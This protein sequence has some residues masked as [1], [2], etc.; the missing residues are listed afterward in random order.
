MIDVA[1]PP[2]PVRA[3]IQLGG[4]KSISNR[5]LII[6]QVLEAGLTF[7]NLSEGDDTTLLKNALARVNNPGD[8][9]INVN[10]AGTDMRFLTALLSVS[11]GNWFLT[12]SERLRQR[13]V[14]ELVSALKELGA[15]I[16]YAGLPQYPPLIIRGK[17]L[18][19]GRVEVDSSISSQ[20]ISALLLIAPLFEVGLRLSMKGETV[21]QPYIRMTVKLL[22]RFGVRINW[23]GNEI[24][25][26]GRSDHP[27]KI[28]QHINVESDWSSASYW[29]SICALSPGSEIKLSHLESSS[30]QPDSILPIIYSRLGVVT[31]FNN[32]SVLLSHTGRSEK[33]FSHDFTDCPDIAQTVAVTCFALGMNAEL[34]GLTTLAIKETDRISALKTELEKL[35]ARVENR[36]GAI[37]LQP[38]EKPVLPASHSV[39]TYHDHRMAMSFAPLALLYG[40]IGIHDHQVVAKSYPGFWEDLKSAGFSVN[41]RA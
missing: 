8:Q 34:F 17:S 10:H 16:S 1:R 37:R 13:P 3:T 30:L 31:E 41:L 36:A 12:G 7:E 24:D 29:Y 28:T 26:A 40:N 23:T 32:G 4:S 35:G 39:A 21:S 11:T 15:D 18:R 6:N 33:D 2:E 38:P 14:G 25:V 20:F 9:E 27:K 22:E 19:G 5:L